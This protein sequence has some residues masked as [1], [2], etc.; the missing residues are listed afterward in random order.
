MNMGV[1]VTLPSA[2][3]GE[4]DLD[5]LN[6]RLRAGEAQLDWSQVTE[7]STAALGALFAGL[8]WTDDVL[9]L[10]TVSP[11]LM[12]EIASALDVAAG[13][14]AKAPR[15]TRSTRK[16][17]DARQPAAPAL[18][19]SSA[20]APVSPDALP[21]EADDSQAMVESGADV[22]GLP[23]AS[24]QSPY[25]ADRAPVLRPKSRAVL[26][27]MLQEMVRL[28]LL[29]PV[30]GE[31]EE[32]AGENVRDRYVIGALAPRSA[33]LDPGALDTLGV[34][35]DESPE[36]GDAEPSS[37]I[38][39]TLFPSSFGLT[40]C[41]AGH[42]ESLRIE[43]R[44]GVYERV[45]SETLTDPKSGNPR[46][47]WK[48]HQVSGVIERLELRE[49][50]VEPQPLTDEQPAV[51]L[52]GEIRRFEDNWIVTL[53]LVNDQDDRK[54]NKDAV[55]LFQPEFTVASPSNEPIFRHHAVADRIQLLDPV[56]QREQ[57]ALA[58][59]YRKRVEFAVGHGVSVHAVTL[60][61][62]STIARRIETCVAPMFAGARHHLARPDNYS[63]P[64]CPPTRHEDACRTGYGSPRRRAIIAARR[65]W[66][67][68]RCAVRATG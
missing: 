67:M 53:F 19:T 44:W 23:R 16:A 9:G 4:I 13:E 34:S 68:D 17:A 30:G 40:C 52:R 18:W 60:E 36:D 63:R 45:K 51:V 27:V 61:G 38:G 31:E 58:M 41:V 42:A 56:D 25:E 3:P 35:A 8:G 47:V 5:A 64:R 48:R 14:A 21:D 2:L 1:T 26:R 49:G 39:G 29:G 54:R 20:D 12:A 59:L 55:W 33:R 6:R 66:A 28:D 57:R 10:A 37:A 7:A 62:D 24:G 65:L 15:R 32:I 50:K 43:A 46:T 11:P 22:A